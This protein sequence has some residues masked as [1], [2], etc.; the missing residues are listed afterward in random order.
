ML[1][2]P[3]PGQGLDVSAS[4]GARRSTKWVRP[5]MLQEANAALAAVDAGKVS[6]VCARPA[7]NHV[8]TQGDREAPEIELAMYKPGEG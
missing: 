1:I 2:T 7:L 6:N 3:S 5:G 4:G 8:V